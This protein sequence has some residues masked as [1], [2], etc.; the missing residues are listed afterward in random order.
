MSPA[1]IVVD[2]PN[3]FCA[4]GSLAVTGGAAVAAAI[5]ELLVENHG[6]DHVVATRDHHIDPGDHFA[7]E[8]D[9]VD[10][11]P[12]HCVAGS[13]G[14]ELHVPLTESQFEAVFEK[15]HHSAAYSGFEGTCDGEGLD[16]WLADHEVTRV[17]IVGIATDYLVKATA[18][19]AAGA[20][21]TT[22]VLLPLTAA[23][24]ADSV[25][26]TVAELRAAGVVV[27]S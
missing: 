27:R 21:L 22:R 24:A 8:P 4:G 16:V 14:A 2:C 26:D 1:P 11:W 18:L 20:G 23:V 19:D 6:Y 12:E 13:P 3:D 9:Y 17:D 7:A 5:G 25:A 10:S 15:G